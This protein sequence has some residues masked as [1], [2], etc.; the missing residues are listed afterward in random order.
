MYTLSSER[1]KR[2][3]QEETTRR[4]EVR[5][6]D[7]KSNNECNCLDLLIMKV[8]PRQQAKVCVCVGKN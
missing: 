6:D 8:W 7:A 4:E 2:R 5:D 1:D 3:Q